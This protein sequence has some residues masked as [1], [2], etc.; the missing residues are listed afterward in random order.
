MR[1]LRAGGAALLQHHAGVFGALRELFRRR[2]PAHV[3]RG[4]P[5]PLVVRHAMLGSEPDLRIQRH[6]GV[7]LRVRRPWQSLLR[8]VVQ[9]WADVHGR[10]VSVGVFGQASGKIRRTPGRDSDARCSPLR[11]V[12]F[13][14][15]SSTVHDSDGRRSL[16][17]WAWESAVCIEQHRRRAGVPYRDR[18][19]SLVGWVMVTACSVHVHAVSGTQ[20]HRDRRRY[21]VGWSLLH[22]CMSEAPCM[23]DGD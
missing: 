23:K 10:A 4:Q 17:T 7:L 16:V 12:I 1:G 14:A 19:R 11:R 13:N 6:G 8:C 5:S 2:G 3:L 15:G 9:D 21:D 22:V 18:Q 20:Q